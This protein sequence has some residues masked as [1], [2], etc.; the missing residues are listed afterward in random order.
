MRLLDDADLGPAET[1][2]QPPRE[3]DWDSDD[4]DEDAA[5]WEEPVVAPTLVCGT[6]TTTTTTVPT[7][8]RG[9]AHGDTEEVGVL[10]SSL[11]AG[12][13]THTHTDTAAAAGRPGEAPR[14]PGA[15]EEEDRRRVETWCGEAADLEEPPVR[16]WLQGVERSELH[17]ARR[18]RA[19]DVW[20]TRLGEEE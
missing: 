7:S 1:A 13:D 20:R 19:A 11:I 9:A 15:A 14:G 2:P 12:T 18:Q 4:W 8:G 10:F 5:D 6:T 17:V 3:E 16:A